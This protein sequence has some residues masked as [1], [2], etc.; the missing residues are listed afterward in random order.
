MEELT[1]NHKFM[2]NNIVVLLALMSWMLLSCYKESDTIEILDLPEHS[3]SEQVLTVKATIGDANDTKTAVQSDGTSIFWTPGDAINLFYGTASSGQFTTAIEEPALTTDFNGTLSVA[4]GTSTESGVTT[5]NFW[6]VYPYNAGNTCTGDGVILTIPTNQSGIAG[7]FA[8]KL[9]PSVATSPGLSLAFYNVGS[10]F[11]FSVTEEDVVSATLTG[12]NSEN[13]AGRIKVTIDGETQRPISEVLEGVNSIVMT[14]EG[15]EFEVGKQYYM[16]VIPQ[17]ME[18]G[19]ELSLTKSDGTTATWSIGSRVTFVRSQYLRKLNAD[20]GIAYTSVSI[21]NNEIWYTS[22]NGEIININTSDTYTGCISPQSIVSNTIEN[23]KGVIKFTYELTSIPSQTFYRKTFKSI[24]LPNSITNIGDKVFYECNNLEEVN[25]PQVQEI[26]QYN[27]YSCSQLKSITLPSSLTNIGVN[28]FKNC[29]NLEEA[30]IN[31][32]SSIDNRGIAYFF[33]GATLKTL[34]GPWATQDGKYI[35]IDNVLVMAAGRDLESAVI[36]S[37]VTEI[38]PYVFYEFKTLKDVSIPN[39]L[40]I[41]GSQAFNGCSNL[42]YVQIEAPSVPQ[43]SYYG[44]DAFYNTNECPIIVPQSSVTSYKEAWPHYS[45]RIG[46]SFKDIPTLLSKDGR[47]NCYIVNS[48]GQYRFSANMKGNSYTSIY[49]Y[50]NQTPSTTSVEVLWESAYSLSDN[51][52]KHD[53]GL[54][55][56]DI[57]FDDEEIVFTATGNEGNA[58]VALKASSGTILWSWHL[59]FV[60]EEI[61]TLSTS[62]MMDRNLGAIRSNYITTNFYTIKDL[63]YGLLY[64]K[65]RKDPFVGKDA[66]LWDYKIEAAS[67]SANDKNPTTLYGTTDGTWSTYSTGWV[68]NKQLNDPCPPGWKIPQKSDFT[69]AWQFSSYDNYNPL[70]K[71]RDVDNIDDYYF[72]GGVIPCAGM[73]DIENYG[74]GEY[75][76]EY[77]PY[78]SWSSD[79]DGGVEEYGYYYL[80]DGFIAMES[81]YNCTFDFNINSFNGNNDLSRAFSVRCCKE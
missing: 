59:W 81:G 73:I 1:F 19:L 50:T 40:T 39:T 71:V 10:W 68:S 63:T 5:Q 24:S 7:S 30:T 17:V 41:L 20:N 76:F 36:P 43:W 57:I 6:G 75:R 67:N 54:L 74:N 25:M 29:N 66:D 3:V 26:G 56:S 18:N 2:K 45:V 53:P 34:R 11:I 65:G 48:S 42:D 16:V 13:L 31:T 32:S 47:A 21:P 79:D 35:I 8:D 77:V 14:P 72:A 27:F 15:G 37:G 70:S 78:H 61:G 49:E 38:Q 33:N 46:S 51:S 9:N 69:G 4:T 52:Y 80:S 62:P 60:N 12:H 28:C 64:Q 23:G 58:L 22:P 44:K 55:I